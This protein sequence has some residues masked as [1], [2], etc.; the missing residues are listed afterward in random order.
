MRYGR[1]AAFG[2]MALLAAMVAL[3]AA[4]QQQSYDRLFV[5]GDSLVDSGNA[6]VFR[7]QSG[8][9]DPAPAALGYFDGR[10]SNG[11]NFADYLSLGISGS[12]AT[13]SARGG[14]NFSV[15]GAQAAEVTGD[16]SPSFIEQIGF[17]DESGASFDSDALVLV[18]L[19]GN[20]VRGQLAA[21]GNGSSNAPNLTPAIAALTAGL[22]DLYDR[23][24]RNFVV[25]GL[26]DIGQIPAV[27]SLGSTALANAGT[28][29]SSGLNAAFAQV[30]AG[31]NTRPGANAAFFDLFN[32]QKTI[33]AN[34]AAYGLPVPLDT[35]TPCLILPNPASGCGD[36]VYFDAIHPTTGVHLAIAQGIGAQIGVAVVPE[37]ASWSL[38]L[39]GFGLTGMVLRRRRQVVAMTFA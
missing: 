39:L 35:T 28:Q 30:V 9:A 20:D 38:M 17:F 34:P 32:F 29:L 33:Y 37:P 16:A 18:T 23:G 10:F 36:N 27:T 3:P 5:F 14:I 6:Q 12:P 7:A 24:A 8:G 21:L 22:G 25:T 11:Y 4:A 19:G 13:A 15:G 1:H 31:F 2:T 26:P